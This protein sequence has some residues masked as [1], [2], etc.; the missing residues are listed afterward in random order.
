MSQIT[1]HILDTSCGKPAADVPLQLM[2]K[3]KNTWKTLAYGVT[4]TDGRV[5][6]L[7][8]KDTILPE[9]IYKIV[10]D[11]DNYFKETD[12]LSFYP[13]IELQ[14]YVRDAAHYHIPLLLSPFGFTTYRGS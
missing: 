12:I 7:L 8:P 6:D 1:T 11:V 4:N 2:Q 13:S 14:F 9:G 5:G 3:T 10:F